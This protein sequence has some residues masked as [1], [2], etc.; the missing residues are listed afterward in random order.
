M[1]GDVADTHKEKRTW[2]DLGKKRS[3]LDRP[4]RELK[5]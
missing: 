3:N 5:S 1:N 4:D 2:I